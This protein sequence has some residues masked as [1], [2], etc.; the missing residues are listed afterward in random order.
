MPFQAHRRILLKN[1]KTCGKVA[2]LKIRM[3]GHLDVPRIGS[4]ILPAA[5]AW[6]VFL[7]RRPI[8]QECAAAPKNPH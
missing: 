3:H 4:F 5:Q 1:F 6:I 2:W 7:F 8:L